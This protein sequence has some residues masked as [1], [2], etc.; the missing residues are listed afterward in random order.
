M[1]GISHPSNSHLSVS[2]LFAIA[3]V[4]A[5]Q[6]PITIL[7][8]RS[9]NM[10]LTEESDKQG[11][12]YDKYGEMNQPGPFYDEYTKSVVDETQ[13][14]SNGQR[15]QQQYDFNTAET[16]EEGTQYYASQ[17]HETYAVQSDHEPDDTQ[18]ETQIDP[19]LQSIDTAQPAG[20]AP[21]PSDRRKLWKLKVFILIHCS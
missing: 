2:S 1:A 17:S 7:L 20:F 14:H 21:R 3:S 5:H 16:Q 12:V 8:R 11:A 18:D 9:W 13:Y 19:A 15:V 6:V 4:H 10:A